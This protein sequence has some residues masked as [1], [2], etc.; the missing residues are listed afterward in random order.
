MAVEDLALQLNDVDVPLAKGAGSAPGWL[1]LLEILVSRSPPI[2]LTGLN[3]IR[4]WA[5]LDVPS[6]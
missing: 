6:H 2:K 5:Q 3:D 1:G 4:C